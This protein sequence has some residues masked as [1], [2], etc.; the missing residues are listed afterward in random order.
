MLACSYICMYCD[1]GLDNVIVFLLVK[2][3]VIISC[4]WYKLVTLR[5]FPSDIYITHLISSC[6]Q[7]VEQLE[8]EV[9]E[10][11]RILADKQEQES[12]MIQVL[13]LVHFRMST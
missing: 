5:Q 13:F 8:Q 12:A 1:E 6:H 9:S 11:R 10:L 3:V 7:Q 4:I 2:S